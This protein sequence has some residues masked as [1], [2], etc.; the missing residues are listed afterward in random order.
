VNKPFHLQ[1]EDLAGAADWRAQAP[2][3]NPRF[4]AISA[5]SHVTEPPEAYSRYLDP[6]FRDVA[7]RIIK[8]PDP[9]IQNELYVFE[10]MEGF[11]FHTA[12]AAGMRPNEIDKNHGGF[13][14]M[15]LGGWEPK[16]RLEAQDRDGILA[17]ILYPSYGLLLC[18]HPDADYKHACFSAYNQWMRDFVQKDRQRLIGVGQSAVRSVKD[19]IDDLHAI[20]DL[21]L[22]GV[23]LPSE[24]SCDLDYDHEDFDPLWRTA[25][26][27]GLPISFHILTGRGPIKIEKP[28]RGGKLAGYGGIVRELQ[29]IANVFVFGRVFE[30]HPDLRIILVESDA[31][32]VPHFCSRMDHAYKRHRFWLKADPLSRLPSEFF[33]ENVYNTFQDDWVALQSLHLLNPRRLLWANDYPHTDSTWPW[34]HDL[35]EHHTAHMTDEQID[36]ILRENVKEL[37]RLE[38]DTRA[39]AGA[40][41]T[42]Q[43][44]TEGT[45]V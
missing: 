28:P 3:L 24:P 11:P 22:G 5:D 37:Y 36:A 41:N 30:R 40:P 31:G 44:L 38:V 25:V 15:H 34:S 10:G 32:W 23:M 9:R 26:E 20:K 39:D 21:G 27:L 6:R 17:E 29:D 35:L 14:D 19:A 13:S 1:Y 43:H 7:P 8:N 18:G 2:R 45:N 33:Y 42:D 12:A 4:R 16:A